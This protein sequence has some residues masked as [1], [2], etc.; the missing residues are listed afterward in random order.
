[1]TRISVTILTFNEQRRIGA[2]LESV[3]ELADEIIVVDSMSTDSTLD[4]CRR[5]GCKIS[6]RAFEGYGAMRQYATSLTTNNY[7]LSI[8]ADEVVSSDLA[9][10]IMRLKSEGLTHRVYSFNRL[11]YYCDQPVRHCGLYPDLQIRLFDKR[12]ANW[13]LRDISERVIFRDSVSPQFIPGELLHYPCLTPD[14]YHI[15]QQ[16]HAM[17]KARV[18]ATRMDSVAPFLPY[19]KAAAGFIDCYLLKGG[20]FDGAAGRA[21]SREN[22]LKAL[23]AYSEARRS[24]NQSRDAG[25]TVKS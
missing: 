14:Q 7:V 9:R 8:D 3:K 10:E 22:A 13:N 16:R 15:K 20:I 6:Q 17:I 1:M 21:I 25:Q 4:I 19:V 24:L 2:C 23:T 12:Y 11:N 5:Y 18:L